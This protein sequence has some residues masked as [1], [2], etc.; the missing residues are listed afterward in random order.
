MKYIILFLLTV[1]QI[2]CKTK[3]SSP[4]NVIEVKL[5]IDIV[6]IKT[7]P[8][9]YSGLILS[10][11][12]K[13]MS[14]KDIIVPKPDF[15]IYQVGKDGIPQRY[16]YLNNFG[17]ALPDGFLSTYD[18][19]YLNTMNNNEKLGITMIEEMP[20]IMAERDRSSIQNRL[21][22]S[23]LL[24]LRKGQQLQI[25]MGVTGLQSING[26]YKIVMTSSESSLIKRSH[27]PDGYNGYTFIQP[28][29]LSDTFNLAIIK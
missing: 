5:G 28:V 19:T 23:S 27:M 18:T 29:I 2:S 24:F 11:L 12:I 21:L 15:K 20:G 7:H 10:G 22:A 13:N 1:L 16:D 25:K 4:D 3:N 17:H 9:Y 26:Q 8:A 6:K 14:G